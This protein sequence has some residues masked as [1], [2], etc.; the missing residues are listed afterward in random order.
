MAYF[1]TYKQHRAGVLAGGHT[2]ATTDA[3]CCVH[4]HICLVFWNGN[5]VSIGNTTR[6]GADI[7]TRLDNLVESGTVH[8][9]VSNDREGFGAPGLN[10]NVIAVVELAHVE[11]AGGDAVVIAMWSTVDIQSAHTADALAAVVVE[12]HRVRNAVVDESLVQDVEHLKEG[13]VGGDTIQR[14]GLEM[15]L[16]ASVLLS[17]NM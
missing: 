10:P 11:L 3:G 4:S 17:P 13:T 16:G 2:G 9:K 7:A 8:H 12:T 1:G 15:A 5:G 6:S 14:I